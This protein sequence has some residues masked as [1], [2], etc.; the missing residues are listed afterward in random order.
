[1]LALGVCAQDGDGLALMS[2]PGLV[3]LDLC[4]GTAQLTS[5]AHLYSTF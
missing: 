4:V 2:P 1:M 3:T 5:P